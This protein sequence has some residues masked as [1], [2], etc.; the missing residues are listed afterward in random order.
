[1]PGVFAGRS[2]RNYDRMARW[3]LPRAYRRLAA[4]VD[5]FAPVGGSVLDVGIGPGILLR[6]LA[7]RRAD[8]R[9]TGVDLSADMIAAAAR[10]LA[11]FG[12]RARTMVGDVT[13]MP[14]ADEIFDLVTTSFSL[15]HWDDVGA[16]GPELARVLRPGGRVV[17]YDFPFAPFDEL[18]EAAQLTA[19]P[20]STVRTG[21][22]FMNC[23]RL[24]L[25][26]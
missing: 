14:F 18:A 11:P 24:T 22:P 25:T 9:L 7:R 26:G 23:E 16:A 2:S 20:R 4:D 17:L 12:G 15:H 19:T 10:N 8:L 13:A 1:M 3:V 21:L 5:A 6:E